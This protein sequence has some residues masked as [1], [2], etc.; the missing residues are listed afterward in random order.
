[1][2]EDKVTLRDV[3]S[4]INRLEDNLKKEFNERLTVVEHDIDQIKAFQNRF[5]GVVSVVSIFVSAI[6][7]FIWDRMIR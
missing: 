5:L 7:T 6:A 3:Y 2:A 4:A 1:M